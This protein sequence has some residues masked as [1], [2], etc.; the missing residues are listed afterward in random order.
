[1]AVIK[2]LTC[3]ACAKVA[4]VDV[5]FKPK[6]IPPCPKCGST[7]RTY[8]AKWIV[9]LSL[10][11]ETGATY[12]YRKSWSILKSDA[13]AH[14]AEMKVSKAR[15]ER[16]KKDVA[17][18]FEMAAPFFET[19]VTSKLGEKLLSSG[20][21][22]SYIS[23]LNVHLKPYFRGKDVRYLTETSIEEYRSHRRAAIP[24]P[25]PAS[26]NRE[27]ATLKRMTSLL[28]KRRLILHD[29]LDGIEMLP[30]DNLREEVLTPGQV[31][32]MY[33]E[34]DRIAYSSRLK[35]DFRVYP[36]HLKIAVLIG[37]NTGM[38]IDGV[39]TLKWSEID[40]DRQEIK[41]VVKGGKERRI[42]IT[43]L[44]GEQLTAWREE[45]AIIKT[46]VIP[47]PKK[48]DSHILITSNFGFKRMCE[49][50]G[51]MDFTFH[52]LRHQFATYFIA[53]TKDIHLCAKILGHST[54]YMTERY[55]HLI[56]GEAEKAM[57]TFTI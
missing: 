37:L 46:Y 47:S 38:R 21:A 15:G 39:L 4:E 36:P 16:Q 44:L 41:K 48:A 18:T 30:E 19:W 26:I 2:K 40:W 56:E 35:K 6:D 49:A 34:C 17:Y 13:I 11:D 5:Q 10:I 29:P 22:K 24:Q 57:K 9:Y 8:G 12:R 14:E 7:D 33:Q 31:E 51:I 54:T 50:I 3:N 28:Y 45:Q 1:M 20:S 53:H 27:V 42:P 32:G 55:G 52:Q 25:K 43:P 23:R